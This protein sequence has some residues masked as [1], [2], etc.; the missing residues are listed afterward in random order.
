M[1]S[2]GGKLKMIDSTNKQYEQY[3]YYLTAKALI[4]V[5]YV[6]KAINDIY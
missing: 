5:Q 3:L 6:E 4:N 1:K 2:Q